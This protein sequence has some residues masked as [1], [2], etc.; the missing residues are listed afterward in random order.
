MWFPSAS[1][2]VVSETATALNGA[3]VTTFPPCIP[4]KPSNSMRSPMGPYITS[5]S[6]PPGCI[7]ASEGG[8]GGGAF[9]AQVIP[10]D[11]IN[12]QPRIRLPINLRFILSSPLLSRTEKLFAFL[13]RL[14]QTDGL[15]Q[16]VVADEQIHL[17]PFAG[18]VFVHRQAENTEGTA[19]H[20][21]AKNGGV[22]GIGRQNS[23]Q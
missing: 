7:I 18:A 21:N 9:C 19:L 20:S 23:R 1:V 8:C 13:L 15:R 14:G 22:I 12:E 11:K 16:S 10:A 2:C 3:P 6:G 5:P 17:N 4:A